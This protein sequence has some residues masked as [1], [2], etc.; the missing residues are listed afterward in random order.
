MRL[1][2][3]GVIAAGLVI[4]LSAT[5]AACADHS[6]QSGNAVASSCKSTT[7]I[8]IATTPYQDSLLMSL[9]QKLGWYAKECLQ[10]SFTNVDFSTTMATLAA[11]TTDVAW[12]N[13]TGVVSTYNRDKNLVYV[14][15]WD[16]FDQ[17]AAMMARP[18]VG[19]TTFDDFVKQGKT[20]K[21][22]TAAVFQELKGK[23]VVT[24]LGSDTGAALE[25]ALRRQGLPKNWIKI[26]NLSQDQGLALFLRGTGDVYLGGIPQRQTLVKKNYATLIAGA[27]LAPPPLNGFV[28]TKSF[29]DKNK[30]ALLK[31]QHVTYE[32]IR[33]TQKNTDE[34]A[35]YV[36]D[37]FNQQ[38]GG[39]MSPADF[40]SFFQHYEHYPLNAGQAQ[41]MIFDPDGFAYWKNIWNQDNEYLHEVS[42]S[43]PADVPTSAF[44]GEQF[45]KAYLAK[46]GADE[47]GWD[48][49]TGSL[50]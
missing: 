35:K 49:P 48:S 4:S 20:P 36:A 27:D 24:T 5:T 45:Q 28:T 12:Y 26:T 1:W 46:Y 7:K 31:L 44:L 8:S 37:T 2:K 38:T 9:G 43:I 6:A 19:L 15:P 21:D 33:Y 47:T 50:S 14:S 25:M 11:A 41:K 30:D 23:N 13:T 17:G 10:V 16:I 34:V 29:Y 40:T 42:K 18:S 32:A 3:R 22:A 39:S